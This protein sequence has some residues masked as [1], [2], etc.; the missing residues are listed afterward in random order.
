M[1]RELKERLKKEIEIYLLKYPLA[2][3]TEM[4]K[5]LKQGDQLP[6]FSEVKHNTLSTFVRY[7]R[8][9]FESYGYVNKHLGGN[10]RKK[11]S[12]AVE[13]RIKVLMANKS[14]RSS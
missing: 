10:G 11:I 12:R 14:H 5:F 2:S 9:K 13:A 4:I 3:T 1:E 8:K 7:Q 6:Q